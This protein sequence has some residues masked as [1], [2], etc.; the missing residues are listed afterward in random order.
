MHFEGLHEQRAAYVTNA[1]LLQLFRLKSSIKDTEDCTN[2][3]KKLII[4]YNHCQ[5]LIASVYQ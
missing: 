2:V 5:I 4:R 1:V 3:I